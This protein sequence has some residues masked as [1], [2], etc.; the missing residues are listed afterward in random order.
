VQRAGCWAVQW[1]LPKGARWVEMSVAPMAV[2]LADRWAVP[3]A[4]SLVDPTDNRMV[5]R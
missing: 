2:I 3:K 1:V 5:A 4:G